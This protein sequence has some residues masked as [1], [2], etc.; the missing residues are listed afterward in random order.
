MSGGLLVVNVLCS[1]LCDAVSLWG[2]LVRGRSPK[3]P[4]DAYRGV[5]VGLLTGF[6]TAGR[7][8]GSS[9]FVAVADLLDE[10]L[11]LERKK[12]VANQRQTDARIV[13]N[14]FGDL[15]GRLWG[16]SEN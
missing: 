9:D 11:L 15:L 8:G 10:A 12:V 6:A 3:P 16:T 1:P 2:L 13:A 5:S 4:C 14:G 7:L